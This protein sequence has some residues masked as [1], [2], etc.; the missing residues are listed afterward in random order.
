[1][2]AGIAAP[3]PFDR[4]DG[5]L[6][7]GSQN[8]KG[9]AMKRFWTAMAVALCAIFLVAGCNDYGNTFQSPGGAFLSFLSPSQIPS[10]GGQFTLTPNGSG[11]VKGTLVQWNGK[12][13]PTTATSGASCTTNITLD[14]NNNVTSSVIFVV[15]EAPLVAVVG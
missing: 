6:C 5:P 11:F 4:T 1:M 8:V 3:P 7:S 9:V 2:C 12:T 13:C 10:G 14:V 15:H